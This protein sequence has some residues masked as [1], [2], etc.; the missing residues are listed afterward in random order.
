MKISFFSTSARVLALAAALLLAAC[1]P[2]VNPPYTEKDLV[3]DDALLGIWR[4]GEGEEASW[5]VYPG[6]NTTYRLVIQEK[7][8]SSPF[9]ARLF[10]LKGQLYLDLY[11]EP[12]GLDDLKR[13]DF[14]KTALVP[15]HLFFKATLSEK[16]MK[17]RA[18]DHDWLKEY[19]AKNPS[20]IAHAILPQ[21][22]NRIVF[23]ASTAAL[24]EFITTRLADGAGWGDASDYRKDAK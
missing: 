24:Q 3:K 12:S 13:E 19:L 14:Y 18:V 10:K 1:I 21:D 4:T 6:E 9:Q 17:L 22:E 7:E 15:S 8:A 5:R 11:P 23:T 2:S 20:A 16:E